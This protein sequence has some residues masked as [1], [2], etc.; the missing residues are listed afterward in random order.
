[1][2]LPAG[3][4]PER[5]CYVLILLGNSC[6]HNVAAGGGGRSSLELEAGSSKFLACRRFLLAESSIPSHV[7]WIHVSDLGS[8]L[9]PNRN[10]AKFDRFMWLLHRRFTPARVPLVSAFDPWSGQPVRL[11]PNH[12]QGIARA[13]N[14]EPS[15]RQAQRQKGFV[16]M[17]FVSR[18]NGLRSQ[19]RFFFSKHGFDSLA[20]GEDVRL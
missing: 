9:P 15:L 19:T 6:V 13:V 8:M 2:R 20:P 4:T 10:T 16:C 18:S 7:T 3:E 1:M 12:E 5:Q 14:E 11:R 17:Y